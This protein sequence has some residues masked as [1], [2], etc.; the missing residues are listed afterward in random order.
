MFLATI[1]LA[2]EC[3]M[4]RFTPAMS[5]VDRRWKPSGVS[6]FGRTRPAADVLGEEAEPEMASGITVARRVPAFDAGI[7]RDRWSMSVSDEDRTHAERHAL[8]MM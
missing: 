2:A 7:P 5:P 4:E 1:L 6:W 8:V 3:N